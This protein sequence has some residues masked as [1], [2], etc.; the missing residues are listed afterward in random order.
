MTDLFPNESPQRFHRYPHPLNS[1]AN[2]DVRPQRAVIPYH[3]FFI[4]AQVPCVFFTY[5]QAVTYLE[6]GIIP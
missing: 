4:N 6:F 2:I 5:S 1:V 3:E